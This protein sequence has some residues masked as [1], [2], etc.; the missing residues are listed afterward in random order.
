M[1]YLKE[2]KIKLNKVRQE[3]T[4]IQKE[5]ILSEREKL[6]LPVLVEDIHSETTERNK[7][8]VI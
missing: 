4:Q 8:V 2:F 6:N 3:V 1:N 7:D 5:T